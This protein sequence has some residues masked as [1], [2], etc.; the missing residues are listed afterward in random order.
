MTSTTYSDRP[1]DVTDSPAPF[2]LKAR[3]AA[4]ALFAFARGRFQGSPDLRLDDHLLQD[5]GLTRADYEALRG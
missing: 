3:R 4:T 1:D 2:A 5:I